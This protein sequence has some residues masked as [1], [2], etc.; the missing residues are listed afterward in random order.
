[1]AEGDGSNYSTKEAGNQEETK[2]LLKKYISSF[3]RATLVEMH[4][5]MSLE[6]RGLI[7]RQITALWGDAKELQEE[8]QLVCCNAPDRFFMQCG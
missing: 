3:D 7:D 4:R 5:I 6:G 2:P 1:M 8:M